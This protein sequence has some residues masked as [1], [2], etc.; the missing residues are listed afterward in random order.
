MNE[1]L[2]PLVPRC[3]RQIVLLQLVV[4]CCFYYNTVR[5]LAVRWPCAFHHLERACRR[6]ITQI[7]KHMTI[8]MWT[9]LPMPC[10]NARSKRMTH[11]HNWLQAIA[12]RI[13]T[14]LEHGIRRKQIFLLTLGVCGD[15]RHDQLER[16]SGGWQGVATPSHG[17]QLTTRRF[18]RDTKGRLCHAR[19]AA[20]CICM[21]IYM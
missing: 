8:E 14:H 18:A 6:S 12:T 5:A 21:L 17:T 4:Q 16:L 10:A 15:R 19:R 3:K 1:Y 11:S 20:M 7:N 9:N 13:L 2:L